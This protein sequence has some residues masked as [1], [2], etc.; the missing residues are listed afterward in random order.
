MNLLYGEVGGS[1][2]FSETRQSSDDDLMVQRTRIRSSSSATSDVIVGEAVR[3]SGGPGG[4]GLRDDS[5]HD[6]DGDT[7]REGV[8]GR[9]CFVQGTCWRSF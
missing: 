4:E 2:L 7:A 9:N 3:V 8:R 6:S 1:A 5:V